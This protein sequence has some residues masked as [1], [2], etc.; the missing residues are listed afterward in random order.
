M[1]KPA[2]EVSCCTGGTGDCWG[3]KNKTKNKVLLVLAPI[4]PTK[5]KSVLTTG[6]G[7]PMQSGNP[8]KHASQC[9]RDELNK[10]CS[11][12]EYV[13]HFKPTLSHHHGKLNGDKESSGPEERQPEAWHLLQ[14]T[15]TF[16]DCYISGTSKQQLSGRFICPQSSQGCNMPSETKM[17]LCL[18]K[19]TSVFNIF[20]GTKG[21]QQL[22]KIAKAK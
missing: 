9:L 6:G 3:K 13:N 4:T 11:Q 17:I 22:Q 14:H 12:L 10:P 8:L 18:T 7:L 19:L 21:N 2:S 15:D 5:K 20:T 16:A 1:H